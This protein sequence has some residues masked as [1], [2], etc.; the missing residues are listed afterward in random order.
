M[1]ITVYLGAHEGNDPVYKNAVI[2]LAAW[3]ADNGHRLVYGGSDEG[4]M[5]VIADTV[6]E[7]GGKVTGIEAQ[8]FVDKGVAHHGLTELTI[9]PNITERR[10]RMIELGDVFIAFPGGTGTLEEIS[11][12]VSKICLDQLT[13]PCIFYNLNGFYDDMRALLRHM[14]DAGFSTTERQHGIYFASNLNDIEH[15]IATHRA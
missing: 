8:M 12:V 1:N 6:L 14:I 4:L 5:A 11:E 13:Q 2:E 9:V 15:I 7:H 3:I 10:T